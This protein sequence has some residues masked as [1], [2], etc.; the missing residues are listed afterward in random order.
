MRFWILSEL[1]F[2]Y[3]SKVNNQTS[4][5][6]NLYNKPKQANDKQT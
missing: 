5:R 6:E 2:A 3:F 4:N 1:R